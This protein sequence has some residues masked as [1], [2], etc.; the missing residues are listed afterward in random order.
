M[1]CL[2]GASE[3]CLDLLNKLLQFNPDKRLSAIQAL[4]H[5]YVVR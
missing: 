4:K 1:D 2:P 5:P 3:D